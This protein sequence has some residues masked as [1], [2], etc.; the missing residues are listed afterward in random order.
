MSQ[1]V[2]ILLP[3]V[4]LH[5][6]VSQ[7]HISHIASSIYVCWLISWSLLPEN[8]LDNF[9]DILSGEGIVEMTAI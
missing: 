7:A 2:F 4:Y 8:S 1:F 5:E 3:H 9:S 6:N